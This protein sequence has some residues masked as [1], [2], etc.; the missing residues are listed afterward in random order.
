MFQ[1]NKSIMQTKVSL[2]ISSHLSDINEN[3]CDVSD[4]A[5]NE[6]SNRINFIK[7]LM[8]KHP[9]IND[10]VNADDE[11]ENFKKLYKHLIK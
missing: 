10:V 9:N 8:N 6:T 7:Y 4:L 5:L 3:R 1:Q 11:W 2:I